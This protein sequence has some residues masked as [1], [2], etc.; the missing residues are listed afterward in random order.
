MWNTNFA[1]LTFLG[2]RGNVW[3]SSGYRRGFFKKNS[4]VEEDWK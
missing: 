3:S 2:N 4:Y 1:L